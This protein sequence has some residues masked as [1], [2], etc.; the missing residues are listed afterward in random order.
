VVHETIV[1]EQVL[2]V[3]L[4]ELKRH[5]ARRVTAILLTVGELEGLG[6]DVLREAFAIVSR[7]TPAEGAV[8]DI[9]TVPGRLEC[10][11]CGEEA[12]PEGEVHGAAVIGVCQACGGRIR[13]VQ[14]R[15]WNLGSVRVLL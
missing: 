12:V 11:D 2:Q 9:E 10:A 14:G 15:G 5:K 6:Q 13:I 7:G 8:F 3:A 1:A 4:E